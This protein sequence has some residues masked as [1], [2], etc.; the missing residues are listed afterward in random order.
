MPGA[1]LGAGTLLVN[2]QG[3]ASTTLLN[4]VTLT[5]YVTLA[6]INLGRGP[7]VVT[8]ETL[9]SIFSTGNRESLITTVRGALCGCNVLVS[10]VSKLHPG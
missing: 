4:T 2:S 5:R 9:P 3:P 1:S 6:L 8:T 7:E 10:D